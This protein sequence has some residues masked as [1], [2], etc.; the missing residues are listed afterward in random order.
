[1]ASALE[2]ASLV[3]TSIAVLLSA[4]S[5]DFDKILDLEIPVYIDDETPDYKF[6]KRIYKTRALP[7]F[8]ISL[9]ASLI[10]LPK[11]LEA[12]LLSQF[13]NLNLGFAQALASYDVASMVFILVV[14]VLILLTIHLGVVARGIRN[15]IKQMEQVINQNGN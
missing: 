1:M 2:S 11:V 5:Q 8:I 3:L 4:W 6:S 10:Y 14:V 13:I 7:I 15:K 12:V 9:I